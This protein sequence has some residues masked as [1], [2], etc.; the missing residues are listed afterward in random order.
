MSKQKGINEPFTFPEKAKRINDYIK[1]IVEHGY[2][3]KDL[4]NNL[5]DRNTFLNMELEKKNRD[6]IQK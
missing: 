6:E 2:I 3:V 1:H 4:S 5:I